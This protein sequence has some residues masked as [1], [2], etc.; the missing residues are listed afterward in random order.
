MAQIRGR[1]TKIVINQTEA[2]M[3][4]TRTE[5]L[6]DLTF[7]IYDSADSQTADRLERLLSGAKAVNNLTTRDFVSL[8]ATTTAIID[9]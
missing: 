5:D 8:K 9:D 7:D 1:Q 4:A 2:S 3:G 6:G